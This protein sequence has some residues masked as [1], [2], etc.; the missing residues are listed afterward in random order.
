MTRRDFFYHWK[1]RIFD[2]SF[3]RG[4]KGNLRGIFLEQ[5][6]VLS[7]LFFVFR[8]EHL[9]SVS[10]FVT[11]FCEVF[12]TNVDILKYFCH[13][14][15]IPTKLVQPLFCQR[16]VARLNSKLWKLKGFLD[17]YPID[18][19]NQ[20]R[21]LWHFQTWNQTNKAWKRITEPAALQV[22][23]R[24]HDVTLGGLAAEQLFQNGGCRCWYGFFGD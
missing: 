16:F 13:K 4:F 18:L 22:Q 9:V 24:R 11:I 1:R 19:N 8:A 5:H 2:G 12:I 15:C 17:L 21:T 20:G 10:D 6:L 7:L 3:K 14:M 23:V